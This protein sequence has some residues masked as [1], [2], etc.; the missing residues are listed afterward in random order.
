MD[1]TSNRRY[2]KC[3]SPLLNL[4]KNNNDNNKNTIKKNPDDKGLSFPKN[5]NKEH[6]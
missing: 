1:Q 3:A 5:V 6:R 4:T 2:G